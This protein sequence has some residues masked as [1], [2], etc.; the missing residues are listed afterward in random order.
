M[1]M[2]INNHKSDSL[3]DN[4]WAELSLMM[5]LVVILLAIAW[6]FL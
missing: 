2:Q 3:P 6:Q 1:T 5:A 4:L